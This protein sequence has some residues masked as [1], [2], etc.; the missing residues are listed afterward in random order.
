MAEVTCGPYPTPAAEI[1]ATAGSVAGE[2]RK[3]WDLPASRRYEF[4]DVARSISVIA[5]N[6][7]A[8]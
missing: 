4:A 6:G 2:L 3:P 7:R 8:F 5:H 1:V